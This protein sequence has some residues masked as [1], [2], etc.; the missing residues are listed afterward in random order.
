MYFNRNLAN[1]RLQT[2]YSIPLLRLNLSSIFYNFFYMTRLCELNIV[3]FFQ[4]AI[5]SGECYL[6]LQKTYKRNFVY[7]G[8]S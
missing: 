7:K 8:L 2:N 6:V 5:F 4:N 1:S 3:I